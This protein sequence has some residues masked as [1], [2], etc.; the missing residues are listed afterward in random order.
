MALLGLNGYIVEVE[1]DIGQTLPNFVIL[2][3]PD[4]SLNEAKERIRSAAQNSGIPLSRRKITANLIPASLPKRGS[5]FDLSKVNTRHMKNSVRLVGIY[6]RI[7]NDKEGAGLGVQRQEEDCRKLA[8]SLGWKVV[9]VY[10]DNDISAYQ[11]RKARAGYN[12]MLRDLESGKLTAILAWHT[13]RLH[14]RTAELE[15][16]IQVVESTA[17]E[18]ATVRGGQ[19]DLSTPDGRMV[20]KFHGAI[21]QREVEHGRDRITRAKQQAAEAGR[22]RG[23]RRPFGYEADG[24]TIRAAEAEVIRNAANAF[25]AGQSL[26]SI[27]RELADSGV[28]TAS[29]QGVPMDEIALRN[30]LLRARNAGLVEQR[31]QV[32]ATAEWEPVLTEDT[33]RAVIS[34]LADPAR[35]TTTGSA[36]RWIGSGLY[37]CGVCSG[38]V[39]VSMTSG[40]YR[41]Y[42]CKKATGHV[43]RAVDTVDDYVL[44]VIAG[45]LNKPGKLRELLAP[46]GV[47]TGP[48]SAEAAALRLRRDQLAIDYAAGNLNGAQVRLATETLDAKIA[49]VESRLAAAGLASGMAD[50]ATAPDPGRAFLDASLG[51][52]R[53]I[54]DA[55]ATVT[56]KPQRRG[57]PKGWK[58][59]EPYFDP[60]SVEVVPK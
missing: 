25:I 32:V 54:I 22:W 59:G 35:T 18:V 41:V 13:D 38:K 39:R 51:R 19:L 6:T 23:G 33:W 31:G 10:T 44:P 9:E 48:L 30:I 53:A 55:L 4:A 15:T 52:K 26:R 21:A 3:L 27:A 45:V 8:A 43:S 28:T 50:L 49:D 29:K 34:K 60:S 58:S 37:V 36:R 16:F 42:R 20:A 1:A 46:S 12:R 40:G 5:G 17:A 2:G 14:R 57:R 47:D 7:S 11:R 24:K 56:I